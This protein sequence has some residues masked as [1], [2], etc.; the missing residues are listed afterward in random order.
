MKRLGRI[1]DL[2]LHTIDKMF[3]GDNETGME[4]L[5]VDDLAGSIEDFVNAVHVLDESLTEVET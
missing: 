3:A 4:E 5:S 1:L 2:F